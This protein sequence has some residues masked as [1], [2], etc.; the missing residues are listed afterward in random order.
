MKIFACVVITYCTPKGEMVRAHFLSGFVLTFPL[1]K[2]RSCRMK[3]TGMF[4]LLQLLG[5]NLSNLSQHTCNPAHFDESR[6]ENLIAMSS[7]PH[8]ICGDFE[9]HNEIWGSAQTSAR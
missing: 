9:A 2:F 8:I 6:L 7:E 3:P 1:L 4:V 5:L